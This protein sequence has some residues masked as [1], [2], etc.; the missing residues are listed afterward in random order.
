MLTDDEQ[1][2]VWEAEY[3]P[4]GKATETVTIVEQNLRFPGQ[5]QDRQTGLH[6]NYFRTYDPVL[7]RYLESDPI[8]LNGGI[9][10]YGY[11]YQNSINNY[12]P[13]GLFGMDDIYGAIYNVTGYSPSRSTV[14]FSAGLGD[15]LLLGLGD[16]IRRLIGSD[17]AVNQCSA[18]YRAGSLA[19]FAFGG[20][21]LAYAGIV[22]GGS[23][24]AASGTAASAFRNNVKLFSEGVLVNKGG[25]LIFL[26][27]IQ[28]L[29]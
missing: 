18:F 10:T 25:H 26:G 12:D 7:G 6:Y 14:N 5:Y 11:A 29:L 28:M 20:T 19:S 13:Y 23:I 21:R 16:N 4:F 9:N 15:A 1:N 2:V 22:K 8:G 27:I 17:D 3:D 24:F